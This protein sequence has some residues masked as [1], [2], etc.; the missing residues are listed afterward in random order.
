[1]TMTGL[2]WTVMI[3]AL[4]AV[5]LISPPVAATESGLWGL[6]PILDDIPGGERDVLHPAVPGSERFARGVEKGK[7]IWAQDVD[8]WQRRVA[9]LERRFPEPLPVWQY[10]SVFPGDTREITLKRLWQV[11]DILSLVAAARADAGQYRQAAGILLSACRLMQSYAVG[12]GKTPY[13]VHSLG[14]FAMMQALLGRPFW[15]FLLEARKEGGVDYTFYADRIR[16]LREDALPVRAWLS[17]EAAGRLLW[18]RQIVKDP[19]LEGLLFGN[20]AVDR[21]ADLPMDEREKIA[22]GIRN[23]LENY[24]RS[25][26]SLAVTL[27][28]RPDE[29]ASALDELHRPLQAVG[30]KKK[31]GRYRWQSGDPADLEETLAASLVIEPQ[32]RMVR[33]WKLATDRLRSVES[34]CRSLAA[35]RENGAWPMEELSRTMEEELTRLW[36]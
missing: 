31:D 5:F 21:F 20:A 27:A 6:V 1:M 35:C 29:L 13:A 8:G 17:T 7:R 36:P 4:A 26:G 9:E 19:Y 10:P 11:A 22:T 3:L 34:F 15:T 33:Q 12:D 14:S 18:A 23:R 16:R 24:Y 25:A 28:E 2:K 32:T 30:E